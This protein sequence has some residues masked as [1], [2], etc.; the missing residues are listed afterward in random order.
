[1]RALTRFARKAIKFLPENLW[2]E[3]VPSYFDGLGSTH[4]INP[5][6]EVRAAGAISW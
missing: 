5:F 6:G 2:K 3:G 4:K 1:M